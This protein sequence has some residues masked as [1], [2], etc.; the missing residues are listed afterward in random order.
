MNEIENTNGNVSGT[1]FVRAE[2]CISCGLCHEIAPDS[3]KETEEGGVH[4]VY[5][6]PD[7]PCREILAGEALDQCP[8]EA[9][10]AREEETEA[11]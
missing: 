5:R 1:Y 11:A 8:V 6:Q 9:I 4:H 10:G 2:D 7:S 3:F